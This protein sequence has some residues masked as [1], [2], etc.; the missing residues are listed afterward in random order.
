[1]LTVIRQK[2]ATFS[3]GFI[4]F[5]AMSKTVENDEGFPQ[6]SQVPET[7]TGSQATSNQRVDLLHIFGHVGSFSPPWKK[8]AVQLVKA[9]LCLP[10]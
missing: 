6:Q 2:K 5:L 3:S 7:E 10:R 9:L 8:L 1:M 4:I